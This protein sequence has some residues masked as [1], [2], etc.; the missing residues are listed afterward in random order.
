[1]AFLPAIGLLHELSFR[2]VDVHGE[3]R[4]LDVGPEPEPV[5]VALEKLLFDGLFL[6]RAQI[7]TPIILADLETLFDVRLGGL[8][9]ERLRVI[10]R[11]ENSLVESSQER[12]RERGP[13][14]SMK[15]SAHEGA[16][17]V[18]VTI[19]SSSRVVIS[20]TRRTDSGEMGVSP[21]SISGRTSTKAARI[22]CNSF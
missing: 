9:R 8:E 2:V 16:Y 19:A 17:G 1:M 14:N 21:T 4:R 13:Q 11:G 18:F 6:A 15:G 10:H 5:F 7:A 22:S 12:E 20:L 3:I